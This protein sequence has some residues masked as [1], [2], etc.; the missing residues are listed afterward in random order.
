[1]FRVEQCSKNTAEIRACVY[2]PI[3]KC[4][5]SSLGNQQKDIK[6][7]NAD[8]A[9]SENG[10]AAEKTKMKAVAYYQSRRPAERLLRLRG[11]WIME[12]GRHIRPPKTL[13]RHCMRGSTNALSLAFLVYSPRHGRQPFGGD[14]SF[15]DFMGRRNRPRKSLFG[16]DTNAAIFGHIHGLTPRISSVIFHDRRVVAEGNGYRASPELFRASLCLFM[17]VVYRWCGV[18]TPRTA[19]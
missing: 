11:N 6:T 8:E 16:W 14:G 5:S 18:P 19:H 10:L 1:M 2:Q 17:S 7:R 15:H 12:Y 3:M 9:V 4:I 13:L